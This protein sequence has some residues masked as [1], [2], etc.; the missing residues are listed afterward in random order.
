[1]AKIISKVCLEAFKNTNK[2]FLVKFLSLIRINELPTKK[3]SQFRKDL[4]FIT[5]L[6]NLGSLRKM[7]LSFRKNNFILQPRSVCIGN[8]TKKANKG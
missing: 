1:M 4:A 7:S 8:T 3:V 6:N 5:A 2:N